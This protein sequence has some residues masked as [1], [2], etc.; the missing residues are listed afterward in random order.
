MMRETQHETHADPLLVPTRLARLRES[1]R[2]RGA[3]F[4]VLHPLH[5]CFAV[6]L[7]LTMHALLGGW[8]LAFV[9]LIEVVFVSLFSRLD[10][11]RLA[12][13]RHARL[14]RQRDARYARAILKEQMEPDDVPEYEEIVSRVD[15]ARARA[16]NLGEDMETMFDECCEPDRLLAAYL[17]LSVAHRSLRESAWRTNRFGLVRELAEAQRDRDAAGTRRLRRLAEQRCTLLRRRLDCLERSER[18]R[19]VLRSQSATLAELCRLVHERV[20]NA[21][22]PWQLTSL[23]EEVVSEV[24]MHEEVLS[25]FDGGLTSEEEEE[26]EELSFRVRIHEEDDLAEPVDLEERPAAS[27][28]HQAS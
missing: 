19:A 12:T 22:H 11:V 25:A 24:E 17:R 6:A 8:G 20:C 15:A 13:R 5:A 27:L 9:I 7:F 28:V 2:W 16:A 4:V 26:D 3:L 23:V 1:D 14:R 18:E 21:V 10:V